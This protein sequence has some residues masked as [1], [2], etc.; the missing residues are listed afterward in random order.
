MKIPPLVYL[1]S[2][3]PVLPLL[4][5]AVGRRSQGPARKWVLTWCAV[6]IATN[7]VSLVLALQ[8]R[9]NHWLTYVS[10]P[11]SWG[12]VLWA[13]SFWQGSALATLAMRLLV[14]LLGI[15]W[16]V[17][18]T[19]I[20]NTQTFSLLAEPF[21]GLL[22]LGSAIYTLVSRALRETGSLFRQD[23]LWVTLGLTIESGAA[24]A[25][26]PTAHWLV[27]A[28]P[29][30]VVR[31]YEVRGFL[32]VVALGAIARGVTCPISASRSGGFFSRGSWPSPSSS[33]VSS[34]PS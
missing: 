2:F 19:A 31:A 24:V 1:G 32:S 23:W 6:V 27:T 30:L 29:D 8:N 20:E 18:V 21:A 12:I 34:P 7:V 10:T 16:V 25:L 17:I 5:A 4:T 14:P 9:N 13:L 22:V 26:P 11:V 28:H 33:S 3:A 15:T